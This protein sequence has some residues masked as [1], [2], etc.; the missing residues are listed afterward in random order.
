MNLTENSPKSKKKAKETLGRTVSFRTILEAKSQRQRGVVFE[1]F[2]RETVPPDVV[3]FLQ[4]KKV[5]IRHY[6]HEFALLIS[7]GQ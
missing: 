3:A 4:K 7:M 6:F 2:S 1:E 5:K